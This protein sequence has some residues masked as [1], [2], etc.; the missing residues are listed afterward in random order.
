M[1]YHIHENG[2]TVIIDDFDFKQA[3]QAD[4]NQ[5][6]KLLATN[7][8][9]VAKKQILNTND[10]LKIVNMFKNPIVLCEPGTPGYRG[11]AVPDSDGLLLRVGGKVNNHG[12]T[13]IGDHVGDFV[14]HHDYHWQFDRSPPLLMLHGIEGV[15][16]SKTLWTN[17]IL[18][19]SE[20]DNDTKHLLST[21]KAVM[22][23]GVELNADGLT[24]DKNGDGWFENG[25]LDE[26]RYL[27]ILHVSKSNRPAIFF[28]FLQID[29]FQGL[30][31]ENSRKILSTI[32][33]HITQDKYVYCHDWDNGDLI[34]F[35]QYLGIHKRQRC[36]HISS[37]LIHR[38]AFDYPDQDY[39]KEI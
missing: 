37:R 20:F 39:I 7:T 27:D 28:P 25:V 11:L 36:D 31:K 23:K 38:A 34:I 9:V 4:I 26:N 17:N 22:I 24:V 16:N 3:S 5:I 35:D 2:W 32:S 21:L 13:G 8:L 19:Y 6:A 10:K 18:A 1:N 14:W 29:H 15:E 30:S 33:K 12:D